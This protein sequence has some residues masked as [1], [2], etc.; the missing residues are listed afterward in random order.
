MY[1]NR[2]IIILLWISFLSASLYAD[3]S[4]INITRSRHFVFVQAASVNDPDVFFEAISD[5][6]NTYPLNQM[7]NEPGAYLFAEASIEYLYI[8]VA[9]NDYIVW[10]EANTTLYFKPRGD[11]L[12]V[13]INTTSDGVHANGDLQDETLSKWIRLPLE[14]AIIV[15]V[16]P[17]HEYCLSFWTLRDSNGHT[18]TTLDINTDQTLLNGTVHDRV[19]GKPLENVIVVANDDMNQ[20]T[21]ELG[22]YKFPNIHPGLANLSFTKN[23][24]Y[25][26][27]KVVDITEGSNSVVNISM[28]PVNPGT[29][30]E[31]ISVQ[32]KYT[33]P[34]KANKTYYLSGISLY[35]T[36]TAT[37]DWKGNT[38]GIVRW[39]TP[40]QTTDSPCSGTSVSMSIDM[41]N[42]FGAEG[43]LRVIAVAD[44]LI[45]SAEY[46]A[47]ME[48]IPQPPIANLIPSVLYLPEAESTGLKYKILGIDSLSFSFAHWDQKNVPSTFPVYGGQSMKVGFELSG[49]LS[50]VVGDD[51][52]AEI[53]TFEYDKK[54]KQV[55]RKG[56]KPIKGMILPF[57]EFAPKEVFLEFDFVWSD[58]H[59]KWMP[60][61]EIDLGCSFLYTTPQIPF[62]VIV[63]VPIYVR[64]EMGLDL[65]FGVGID[66]WNQNGPEYIGNFQFEPLGKGVLGAGVSKAVCVEGYLGGGFHGAAVFRPA[67]EWQKPYIILLGGVQAAI[68][69]WTYGPLELRYE[70]WPGKESPPMAII[71]PVSMNDMLR[72]SQFKLLPR[73]YLNYPRTG[74]VPPPGNPSSEKILAPIVYPYSTPSGIRSGNNMLVVWIADDTSR[75]LMNRTELTFAKYDGTN[76]TTMKP[77]ADDGTADMNPQLVNLP[78]GDAVCIWQDADSVLMDSSNIDEFFGHMDIS[79]S[80]YDSTNGIWSSPTRLS[81][82]VMYDR[83]PKIAVADG[84][85]MMAVWISNSA[86]DVWGS[87]TAP[88]TIMYS[89]LKNGWAVPS[90]LADGF[91]T[92]LETALAYN[93]TTGT[94]VFC[95]DADDNF[96]T[97]QDQELWLSTYSGGIWTVPVKLTNDQN[98]DSS[99]RVVYGN[100][101]TLCMAWMK[102]N[103]IRFALGTDVT[104]SVVIASP[105]Q[106]MQAR[107]FDLVMGANGQIAL[108]WND[109]SQTYNDIF[110]AYYEPITKTWSTPRQLTSDD[111]MERFITSAFDAQGNLFCVYDKNHTQYVDQVTTVN[112]QVVTVKGVPK[113]GQS[114]LMYLQ[115]TLSTDLSV[116]IEDVNIDPANPE[117]GTNA[118][119]TAKIKNIGESP[120]Q[121]VQIAFYDGNPLSGGTLIDAIKTIPDPIAGGQEATTSVTWTVPQTTTSKTLYVVVD[122]TNLIEDRNRSNNSVNFQ[123]LL[124]DITIQDVSVQRAGFTYMVTARI[125]NEG[126]IPAKNFE[127][128]LRRNDLEHTEV[129]GGRHFM[130][131]LPKTYQDVSFTLENLP[132]G[133]LNAV[134]EVDKV[135]DINEFSEDDN[136]R[137]FRIEN[138]APADFDQNGKVDLSDLSVMA[139]EWLRTNDNLTSDIA[140]LFLK[141]GKVDLSDFAELARVWTD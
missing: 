18:T 136:T 28:I 91:G 60:A 130:E 50:G 85:D 9:S 124:P 55:I 67:F 51:G 116:S 83:S 104:N 74:M 34:S 123:I 78:N 111:A 122:P 58:Y 8:E 71:P 27:K 7:I 90:I 10:A 77:L 32:S 98:M 114:D 43:G 30:P 5:T 96:D 108:V 119:I 68:G 14:E 70:W 80:Q 115:Y 13:K 15:D 99:P 141:D 140:P 93:G 26:V 37:I 106:S 35:D 1:V 118:T 128:E 22:D 11:R 17:S 107:D 131:I 103:D 52:K 45:Q 42:D 137:S 101:G 129:L 88:N 76:W 120:A 82:N 39:I 84:D 16:D 110:V 121:N 87:A 139:G 109:V 21:N 64:A 112:G 135:N 125:A 127:M 132:F 105:G 2:H 53:F 138:Y 92:I 29:A 47:N 86:N 117:P 102:D 19:T 24:Y 54:K 23:G 95:T 44:G 133:L 61:G 97:P 81:N 134:V 75:N 41:G 25:P 36:F 69:P 3:I 57:I 66:G 113:P 4:G 63:G 33:D 12:L 38:P 79:V 89:T 65:D 100:D 56:V 59:H 46:R 73:D 94:F 6:E 20:Q 62:M 40:L 48:V 126:T 49:Q 31:V 72:N